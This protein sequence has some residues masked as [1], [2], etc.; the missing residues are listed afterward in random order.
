[1]QEETV[2][3][4]PLKEI[5]K[6]Y[7]LCSY[8]IFLSGFFLIP[9]IKWVDT[10]F[11]A[12]ILVPYIFTT[13]KKI[14]RILKKSWIIKGVAFLCIYLLLTPLWGEKGTLYEYARLLVKFLALMCFLC[15]TMELALN[16]DHFI[17]SVF[18]F[19]AIISV[20]GLII[21]MSIQ[22]YTFVYPP[23]QLSDIG[24]I[25][26]PIFVGSTYGMLMIALYYQILPQKKMWMNI[27]YSL[28]IFI[29]FLA[30]VLAQSRGPLLA[31]LVSFIIGSI[32]TRDLKMMVIIFCIM[33]LSIILLF[34]EEKFVY[35][36]IVV[37]NTSYRDEIY[38]YAL[39]K[40]L[41]R[42]MLGYGIFF[43]EFKCPISLGSIISHPHNL[44]LATWLHG[45]IVGLILLLFV[46]IKALWLGFRRFLSDKN[47][48]FFIWVIFSSICIFTDHDKLIDRPY[49]I[50]LFLW[51]VF[52]LLSAY[53][54]TQVHEKK[55]VV[56]D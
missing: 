28:I 29:M 36:L 6:W 24:N 16:K 1:M 14:I 48:S 38:I 3:R 37:R 19:L 30:V 17:D 42:P 5:R 25:Y 34:S 43:S 7:F 56:T 4:F 39:R 15:L 8:F 22:H 21:Y 52:G 11:Y 18:K 33:A 40:I 50:Y 44:Y 2:Q 13:D 53:E 23:F 54:V 47:P 27:V 9:R 51:M 32:M 41:E 12:F 35:N 26:N 31:L 10:F 20:L 46:H 55:R 45:G 49:V